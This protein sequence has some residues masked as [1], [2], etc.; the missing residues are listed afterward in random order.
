MTRVTL[1]AVLMGLSPSPVTAD[2]LK[3]SQLE[4]DL[5]DLQRQVQ[6][7]SR[8][9]DLQRVAPPPAAQG[10]GRPRDAVRSVAVPAWVDA[11]KWQRIQPGMGELEVIGILGSPT[12]MRTEDGARLLLYALEIGASGFLVGKVRLHDRV[13]ESVQKPTLQ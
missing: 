2:E 13:V 9:V 11:A 12:S 10:A 3:V 7:L 4:Q 5:R 8:Q 6:T 1:M